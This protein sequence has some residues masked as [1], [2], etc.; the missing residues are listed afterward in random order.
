MVDSRIAEIH[1]TVWSILH[2]VADPGG[3]APPPGFLFI[4]RGLVRT[5]LAHPHE[6]LNWC[7]LTVVD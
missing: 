3:L 7:I 2:T 6:P 5:C 1:H 4:W